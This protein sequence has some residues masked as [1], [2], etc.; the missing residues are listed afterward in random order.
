MVS[1]SRMRWRMRG[2]WLW[3]SFAA[4]TVAEGVLLHELPI[5]GDA[6][7][8]VPGTILA[9]FFNLAAVALGAPLAGRLLRRRRGDLP[10]VVADN[11]AGTALVLA[12]ALA[13]LAAGLLHHPAVAEEQRDFRAQSDAVRTYVAHQA[14]AAYRANI[15]LADSWKVEA[16]SYRTCVP[17]PDPKRWLCLLVN[18]ATRPAGVRLDP[19]RAP[20]STYIGPEA[21]GH[22][23]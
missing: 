15:A 5:A 14:P 10:K 1:I 8:I 3:P 13:L 20:N 7:G 21:I 2:A 4:L 18:T 17:G 23:R 19:N 12:T 22:A 11:Y 16:D 9:G 6:T